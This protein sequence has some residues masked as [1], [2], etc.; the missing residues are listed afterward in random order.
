M[1][2]FVHQ[3]D[4]FYPISDYSERAIAVYNDDLMAVKVRFNQLTDDRNMHQHMHQ[5]LTYVVRGSF[6]FYKDDEEI[7]VK[8]GDSLLFEPHVRHGCIPLEVN[9][10]L[11][12]VF[13]PMRDDFLDVVKSN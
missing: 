5:Q 9:S 11:L 10:E 8:A 2:E 4:H 6:R 7:E 12:D 1:S 3:E 13:T